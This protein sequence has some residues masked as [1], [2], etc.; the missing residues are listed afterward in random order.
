MVITKC[1]ICHKTINYEN[2]VIA[3]AEYG[4]KT[5]EFCLD[6][7]KPV[8]KFLKKNGFLKDNP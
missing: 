8:L 5:H 4:F 7:G 1:D 6:C 3:G 2:R